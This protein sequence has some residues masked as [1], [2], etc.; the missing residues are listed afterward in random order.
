MHNIEFM[1]S[2]NFGVQMI[3]RRKQVVLL[4]CCWALNPFWHG[5]CFVGE[6][7]PHGMHDDGGQKDTQV[8]SPPTTPPHPDPSCEFLFSVLLCFARVAPLL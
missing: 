6:D 5:T 1:I 4:G 3:W 2:I 7:H 8:L